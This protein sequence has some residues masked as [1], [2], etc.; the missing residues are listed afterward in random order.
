[1]ILSMYACRVQ[2]VVRVYV[3]ACVYIHAHFTAEG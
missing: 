3:Y 1:M 2:V